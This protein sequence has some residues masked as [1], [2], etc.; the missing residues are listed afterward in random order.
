MSLL[1]LYTLSIWK[2][3][4]YMMYLLIFLCSSIASKMHSNIDFALCFMD[5][6]Q[7]FSHDAFQNLPVNNRK[8]LATIGL[9]IG[10]LFVQGVVSLL[11]GSQRFLPIF[12]CKRVFLLPYVFLV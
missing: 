8:C 4:Y 1:E 10:C 11:S 3:N 12:T 2:T 5:F 6:L 7:H 9:H